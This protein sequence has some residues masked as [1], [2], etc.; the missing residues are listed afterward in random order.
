VAFGIELGMAAMEEIR[1]ST[2]P[3]PCR[4]VVAVLAH[5]VW[6]MCARPTLVILLAKKKNLNR[7]LNPYYGHSIE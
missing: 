1:L 4:V 5:R 7:I 3:S 2:L 6:L